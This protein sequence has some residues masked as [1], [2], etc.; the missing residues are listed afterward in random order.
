MFMK[1]LFCLSAILFLPLGCRT[2]SGDNDSGLLDNS[3]ISAPFASGEVSDLK[4]AVRF[5]MPDCNHPGQ[6]AGA[7][8]ES[9]DAAA[10]AK[11]SGIEDHLESW[12]NNPKVKSIKMAYFSFSNKNTVRM[13]CKAAVDRGLKA[14]LYIHGQSI[15]DNVN[16][17]KNCS[18][19]NIQVI[20]RGTT[21]G[22]QNGYLQH[23]KI[24]LASELENMKPQSDLTGQDAADALTSTVY[25]ASSSANMSSYGTSLHFENWM[26]FDAKANTQMAQKNLC[27]FKGIENM[28]NNDRDSYAAIYK[29]CREKIQAPQNNDIVFYPNPH[30]GIN[31]EPYR[32][33]LDLIK[34]ANQSIKIGI[35]R[36][37]STGMFKALADKAATI[38][39]DIIMDD[40]T[41]RTGVKSGGA[42]LDV[43]ANDVQAYRAVRD[44]GAKVTFMETNADS[45]KHL[46]H[47]K[48]MIVD[49]KI[50]FAGAGNFTTTSLNAFGNGN[51]EQFYIIRIPEMVKAYS[52]AWEQLRLLSTPTDQHAVGL[53]QERNMTCSGICDFTN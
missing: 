36:F 47:N 11:K 25:I 40:D 12:V 46:F 2:T 33:M 3:T 7:W 9:S 16:T 29:D 39:V 53:N 49:D 31:P 15:V 27:F 21:F 14:V 20:E 17:L 45:N 8:C 22:T 50:L 5:N 19:Q 10:A 37:T 18:P 30:G 34:G 35:H 42:A 32:D 48:F 28:Q 24:F 26:F 4:W 23:A 43:G 52:D 13:L 51:F 44:G 6:K 41:L 1:K 38:P